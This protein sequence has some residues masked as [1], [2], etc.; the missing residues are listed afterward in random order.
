MR[1]DRA[2]D[3]AAVNVVYCRAL[4]QLRAYFVDVYRKTRWRTGAAKID[5]SRL[6]H[7]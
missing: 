7:N 6:V 1:V 3:R 5:G 4:T 2:T